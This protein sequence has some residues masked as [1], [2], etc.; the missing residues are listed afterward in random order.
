VGRHDCHACGWV[1]DDLIAL[2]QHD[3][4]WSSDL[5]GERQNKTQRTDEQNHEHDG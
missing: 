1:N 3:C 4:W 5:S 2:D